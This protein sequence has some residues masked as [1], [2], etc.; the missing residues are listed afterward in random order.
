QLISS[1]QVQRLI[2]VGKNLMNEF[3]KFSTIEKDFFNNTEDLIEAIQLGR[4]KFNHESI[5]LKGARRFGFE[6]VLEEIE[7]KRHETI[8]EVDLNALIDNLNYYRDQLQPKTKI[9]CMIK[10]AAY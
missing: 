3:S 10:A 6:K 7:L 4:I 8:L 1:K 9:M 5:L 2:G